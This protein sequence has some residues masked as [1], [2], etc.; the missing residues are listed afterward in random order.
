MGRA[1]PGSRQHMIERRVAKDERVERAAERARNIAQEERGVA[2]D[3]LK[4][5]A[6]TAQIGV[7]E[8]WGESHGHSG[9][10]RA[11]IVSIAIVCS[12]LLAGGGFT[13]GPRVLLW[14]GVGCAVALGGYSLIGRVWSDYSPRE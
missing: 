10:R 8:T 7:G 3:D 2:G 6:D 5:V 11:W 9:T 14:I 13:F 1:G 4:R 12:I